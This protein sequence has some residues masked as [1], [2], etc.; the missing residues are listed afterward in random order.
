MQGSGITWSRTVDW[1]ISLPCTWDP[2]YWLTC[3]ETASMRL[4]WQTTQVP[5]LPRLFMSGEM[6]WRGKKLWWPG[7]LRRLKH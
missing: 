3:L 4:C 6:I 2:Q 7:G 5:T 1:N